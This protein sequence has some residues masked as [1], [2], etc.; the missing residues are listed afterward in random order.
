[1]ATLSMV[2]VTAMNIAGPWMIRILIGTV[3]DNAGG[4][5]NIERVNFLA[6]A[7]LIIYLLKAISQFGTNYVSHYAAWKILE[8]IRSHLYNHLQNLSLRFFHD[9][10]T[11]ELMS[12]VIDDTRNFEQLLAHAIPTVIVNSLMVIGVSTILFTMNLKLAL[13]TL[14][15]IPL[16]FWMVLSSAKYQG[17]CSESQGDSRVIILQIIFQGLKKS[18]HLHRRNMRATVHSAELPLIQE[19]FC[20]P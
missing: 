20:A 10:Q 12:R 5:V 19:L 16:L 13:Y 18:R 7:L 3:T 1:M 2:V 4:G 14:I 17:L 8:G 6:L 11:C 15:P 9:K